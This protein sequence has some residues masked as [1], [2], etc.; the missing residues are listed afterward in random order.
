MTGILALLTQ[1][2]H[3]IATD[4]GAWGLDW[5]RFKS[6]VNDQVYPCT[7]LSFF[8]L[9]YLMNSGV[10]FFLRTLGLKSHHGMLIINSLMLTLPIIYLLTTR[11]LRQARVLSL[12]YVLAILLTCTTS[13]Y[14]YTGALEVQAGVLIG[15]FLAAWLEISAQP[16]RKG[17]AI[18]LFYFVTCGLLLA[19]YKD[20]NTVV[21]LASLSV[22]ILLRAG[23]RLVQADRSSLV[24]GAV[25]L[26]LPV[27]VLTLAALANLAYNMFR[28][29]SYLP[30]AYLNI[31]ASYAPSLRK[32]AEFFAATF[33][34]PNGG[35]IIFWMGGF[36]GAV[37]LLIR[38]Q[39]LIASDAIL[40]GVILILASAIGFSLW[41][42]PF[43]WDAWG[44]RLMVPAALGTLIMLILSAKPHDTAL[45]F[46]TISVQF[47]HGFPVKI[48]LLVIFSL[49]LYFSLISYYSDRRALMN[50]AMFGTTNCQNMMKLLRSDSQVVR[51]GFW[52]SEHYYN[53]ASERFLHF[54]TLIRPNKT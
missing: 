32:S 21:L 5:S 10:L 6:C 9:A 34:S 1:P 30:T 16:L 11:P 48:T 13:M 35:T 22:V 31:A 15:I 53:C 49:S 25:K 27:G 17:K 51:Q 42:N 19:F 38:S 40:I 20:T 36:T 41:W 54:P 3:F 47:I 46:R 8:P 37:W 50:Q 44:D 33:L 2:G 4:L 52:R 45:G 43:G 26:M 29:D 39:F 12:I 14:L 23:A 24:L 7:E 18:T 28:Y